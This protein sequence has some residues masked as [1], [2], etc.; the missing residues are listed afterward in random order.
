[1]TMRFLAALALA[2]PMFAQ[3]CTF[4]LSQTSFHIT[5]DQTPGL[6]KVTQTPGSACTNYSASVPAD[7]NWLHITSGATGTPGDSGVTFT[8]DA[9]PTAVA[10][11]GSMLIATQTVTVTQDGLANCSY[12]ISPS[13]PTFPVGGGDGSFTVQSNCPWQARPDV[14]WISLGTGGTAGTSYK[15]A[16]NTC[17]AS[18]AGT[19]SLLLTNLTPPPALTVTQDGSPNNMSLRRE[20]D[21]APTYSATVGAAAS[22]DRLI[23]TTGDTCLWSASVDV[24]WISITFGSSGT[25]SGGI[26]YSILENT[27]T[28]PRTGSIHVGSLT[29]TIT[30]QP[31]AQTSPVL[32]SVG[33]A[34]S[35]NTDAVSP[36]EI[37]ALFGSNLGPASI[38]T[39]QVSNGVVIN[40]LAGTQVLFDGVAAPMVYTLKGQ[41]S[42]VVP[43]GVAGKTSTKVQVQYQNAMSNTL[44]V[45]VQAATPAI[46]SLDSTGIGPGA[47]LN[48]DMSVN[49]TGNPAARGSI[50]SLYC[51]GGGVT[52]PATSPDGLVIG[53]PPPK[54]AAQPPAS[55]KVTI[56][57]V[58]AEVQYAGGVPGTIAGFT[59]INVKVPEVTPGLALPVI[60]KVGDFASGSSVTVAVK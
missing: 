33:N 18:R 57:G 6:V 21:A 55:V 23:V 3:N 14:S 36:G 31:P 34:A 44:T 39:L 41:V 58:D 15:V 59:Q 4:V 32:S 28:V 30:Q 46:F 53:V 43:Y 17:L 26:S 48:Q 29:F 16:S 35:Y 52:T 5:A 38:V 49:S 42:V 10:R 2:A 45:P 47:I 11:A 1:M 9:N 56:G 24:N 27:T 22:K 40:S 12:K 13:N 50:I 8:A 60:V 20:N 37:V 51:T 54:L 25:G 19:I 7:T